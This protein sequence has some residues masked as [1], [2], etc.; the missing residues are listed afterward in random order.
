L[1]KIDYL[2]KEFVITFDGFIDRDQFDTDC[3]YLKSLFLYYDKVKKYVPIKENVIDEILMWFYRDKVDFILTEIS[4]TKLIEIKERYNREL[5]V[6][7]DRIFTPD[8]IKEGE[9]LFPE[10]IEIVNWCLKRNV[11][12][13]ASDT[14][15][16]KSP[17]TVAHLTYLFKNNLVDK[18]LIVTPIGTTDNWYYSI[19]QFSPFFT[20]DDFG[21]IDNTN[22]YQPFSSM[23]DKKIIITTD[24][25]LDDIILSYKLDHKKTKSNKGIRWNKIYCDIKKEL[26]VTTLGLIQDEFH[27]SKNPEAIRTKAMINIKSMFDY[28]FGLTATPNINKFEHIYTQAHIIDHSIIPMSYNAFLLDISTSIGDRFNR[29][30]ITEY[31][32]ERVNFYRE[33]LKS[34]MIQVMKKDFKHFTIER[35]PK[36]H[37]LKLHPIQ[38]ELYIKIWQKEISKLQNEYDFL[39]VKQI[40]ES[41]KLPQKMRVIDCPSVLKVEDYNDPE[42]T[43]LLSKWK[44]EYDPKFVLLKTLLKN[45]IEELGEKV[46]IFDPSPHVLNLLFNEFKNY[47]PLIIH[48]QV[49]N[50][51]DK[52]KERQEKINQFNNTEEN[53]LFLL[54][55]RTSSAS[56]NLQKKCRRTK[57]YTIPDN[58]EDYRQGI[59]RIYRIVSTQ[60]ALI[61][62]FLFPDTIDNFRYERMVNRMTLSD[63]LTKELDQ[64]TLGK[65]LR[66]MISKKN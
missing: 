34:V 47:K 24:H 13:N 32:E 6:Y 54:S 17:C 62:H 52:D 37:K 12:I 46:I 1:I 40:L 41:S 49:E 36:T 64:E 11:Y 28:R 29:Y 14:G 55:T 23:K 25:I 2:E 8:L 56:S 57:F 30:S 44:L 16:G 61:D 19:L 45:E 5:K 26:N 21:F 53:R 33:K 27:S 39:Q 15:A 38:Q 35:I 65:L 58:T 10:Q 31:N 7:R 63:Q 20:E 22:K 48:G 4:K 3:N 9:E 66:G 43:K 42:I 59:D 18:F 50:E 60:D 51:K